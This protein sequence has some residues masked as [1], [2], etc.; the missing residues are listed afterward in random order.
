MPVSPL[1]TRPIHISP[2]YWTIFLF[3]WN[4]SRIGTCLCKSVSLKTFNLIWIILKKC[5]LVV[6]VN[7]FGG[8]A[9]RFSM[10]T[11]VLYLVWWSFRKGHWYSGLLQW[12]ADSRYKKGWKPLLYA[13][14]LLKKKTFNLIW[15]MLKKYL[16][17]YLQRA[18]RALMQWFSTA[19]PR[20]GACPRQ[21]SCRSAKYITI[22]YLNCKMQDVE[23]LSTD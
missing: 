21:L 7:H 15:I 10:Y 16:N 2:S 23:G 1:H 22:L 17:A 19:G 13:D 5:L 12:I 9:S 20:T 6:S 3:V 4:Y 8:V 18:A 11:A 14:L